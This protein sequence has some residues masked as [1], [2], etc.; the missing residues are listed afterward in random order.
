MLGYVP[1]FEKTPYT[2]RRDQVI[3]WFLCF[4]HSSFLRT[5][6][7]KDIVVLIAR[8]IYTDFDFT[9]SLVD[10]KGALYTLKWYKT[11][12]LYNLKWVKF[13]PDPLVSFS[14]CT[15]C[16]LPFI[17]LPKV[18]KY[19]CT[20]EK[21]GNSLRVSPNFFTRDQKPQNIP[22]DCIIPRLPLSLLNKN[23]F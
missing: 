19:C 13:I 7:N 11:R 4:K 16:L 15:K 8:L 23:V 1:H 18:A 17:Y 12:D 3:T 14:I 21:C 2:V 9:E 10:Q 20:S 22:S 6:I 5:C